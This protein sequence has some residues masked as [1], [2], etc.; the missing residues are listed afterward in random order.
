MFLK[1]L[2]RK[3]QAKGF[4]IHSPFAFNFITNV[5]YEK[6]GYTAFSD[7]DQ[8]LRD[9]NIV[10]SDEKLHYLSY[11]LVRYFQPEKILELDTGKGVNTLYI[12]SASKDAV[13]HCFDP[14]GKN[15]LMARNLH[16]KFNKNVGFIDEIDISELYDGIFVYLNRFPIDMEN[17]LSMSSDETFWVITGIKSGNGRRF[18]KTVVADE[19]A[20]ITFDM[21]DIGIVILK[22]SY[23]KANYLV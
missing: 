16:T 21:K 11:R 10:T 9:H 23:H 19:R 14:E 5:I 22:E 6:H 20:R 13:C 18:W 3:K 1:W 7:I 2:K 4:G 15:I 17:L 8:V 12:S